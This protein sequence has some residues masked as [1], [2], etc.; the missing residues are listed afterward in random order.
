MTSYHVEWADDALDMLA[1]IWRR[2]SNRAAVNAAQNQIDALLARDPYN[3]GQEVHEGLYQLFEPP[4]KVSYS[5]N[6]AQKSVEVSA[7]R[8]IP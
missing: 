4:L 7:V 1:D 3:C 8:Y 5:I 2:A 6:Q